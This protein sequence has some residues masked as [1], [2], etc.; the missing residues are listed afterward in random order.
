M[1]LREVLSYD[2]LL[3]VPKYSEVLPCDVCVA[4]KITRNVKLN[5]PLVSAAMDTVSEWQMAVAMAQEGGIAVIH[6]NMSVEE[7]AEQ[8]KKVKRF[9]AGLIVNP[10]V[11]SPDASI[12]EAKRIMRESNISGLPV[13]EKNKLVGIITIRDIRF[14]T[15][16]GKLVSEVMTSNP[17]TIRSGDDL[18]SALAIMQQHRIE[19]LPVVDEDGKLVGLVTVKD[20]RKTQEYPNA[21][22]DSRG[23]LL[24]AAAVGVG[25]DLYD[26]AQALVDAGADILVIDSAHGFSKNVIDG[27][28]FLKRR[29]KDVDVIAGNI[30][31]CDGAKALIDAGA[32]GIKVGVGPGSICTTRVITG[33]GISQATAVYEC[34]DVAQKYNIPIIADGGIRYSGDITKAIALGA[35]ATMIGNLF[36]GTEEA[37]GETILYEGRKY[38]CYRG[39]GSIGAMKH[40]AGARD[41]YSQESVEELTK[42]VPEGIEGRVPYRGRV[43]E[44][45]HQLIGGL[46]AGMGMV[47]AQNIDELQQNAEFVKVTWSGLK[48]S[49]PHSVIITSEAPN[50]PLS[51][52]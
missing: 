11:I 23:R 3:L 15:N 20:I 32:D 4:T 1:N 9:E 30:A 2:D 22:K 25:K 37:P 21:V 12:G 46:K 36:A 48:E 7:Q 40:G 19:K 41:R 24:V 44:I 38:K 16:M 13:V 5:I 28:K 42:L 17:V 29:Y 35:Q 14:E 34:A 18:S 33:C 27:V 43:A 6:R 31:T 26:R 52:G 39:M 10:L 49:H 8:I 51:G 50:Y 47:G 45:I